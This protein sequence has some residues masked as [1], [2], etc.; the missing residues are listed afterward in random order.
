MR[1]TTLITAS[2]LA[3][4]LAPAAQAQSWGVH[5][6]LGSTDGYR[7]GYRYSYPDIGHVDRVSRLAHEIDRTATFI[8]DQAERNNRRPDRAEARALADLHELNE[9]AAHFHD[10]LES[11]RQNP[12][13][14]VNDFADLERAFSTAARSLR[15]IEPRSYINR[16]ME[17]IYVLMNEL[18]RYYGRSS[19]YGSWGH[20]QYDGGRYDHGR[21]GHD[22]YDQYDQDDEDYD[23][24]QPPYNH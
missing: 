23:G 15:R 3:L 14:T 7:D 13:H 24:Y 20:G 2:I 19:G 5:V 9:Q 21:Y 1:H 17:Q 16:G 22:Q 6:Q 10:V 8:H 12:S 4:S 18:S 11:Y